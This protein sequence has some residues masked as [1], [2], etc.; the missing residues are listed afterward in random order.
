MTQ[1]WTDVTIPARSRKGGVVGVGVFQR[2]LLQVLGSVEGAAIFDDYVKELSVLLD[3]HVEGV[4]RVELARVPDEEG[5]EDTVVD[6]DGFKRTTE[7]LEGLV[8]ANL[9]AE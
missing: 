6:N 5:C 9:P 7:T 4:I 8:S 2:D 1:W 3:D